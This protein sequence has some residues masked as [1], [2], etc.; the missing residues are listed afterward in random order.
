MSRAAQV[1]L[2]TLA[3]L[4]IAFVATWL[5]MPAEPD[6][7]VNP[8]AS[9]FIPGIT[10]QF[11]YCIEFDGSGGPN[12]DCVRFAPRGSNVDIDRLEQ[13]VRFGFGGAA[14]VVVLVG[15]AFGAARRNRPAQET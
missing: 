1:T 11:Y 12:Q 14:V 2:L 4:V 13:R 7:K 6:A 5:T 15:L 3:A 10:R 9:L 8:P